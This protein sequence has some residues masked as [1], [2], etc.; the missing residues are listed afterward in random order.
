MLFFRKLWRISLAFSWLPIVGVYA[1]FVH[2]GG[3]KA[4]KRVSFVTRT[5]GRGLAWC[6][7][8]NIRVFGDF[9]HFQGGLIVSNHC[10]YLDILTHAS[11][12]PIRFAPKK[13]IRSWPFLGWYLGIS[14]PIWIDRSS[15]QKSREAVE[16]FR[17]TM[18]H[19]IPLLVYPEGTSTDGEHGLL[20]FKS[21]PFEAVSR[22]KFPILPILTLYRPTSDGKSL[23]W[24]GNDE[25]MPHV[26][27]V[28]GYRRIDIDVH[29]LPLIQP[30]PNEDRKALAER[31]HRI[32]NEA[33]WKLKNMEMT[34]K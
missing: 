23:C 34:E 27:R 10:G 14:R 12:F 26:W 18:E 13:E 24:Y 3:W 17:A 6:F 11:L 15:R 31:V 9:S 2:L 28:L 1:F 4:I 32:M 7:H 29:I 30:Q 8:L 25:L 16:S 33:Y 22:S 21:T 19:G 5:W 20:P